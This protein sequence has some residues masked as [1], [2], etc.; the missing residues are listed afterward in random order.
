[1]IIL[2][3]ILLAGI[4]CG[5]EGNKYEDYCPMGIWVGFIGLAVRSMAVGSTFRKELSM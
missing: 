4:W 5:K 2:A 1:M 3:F